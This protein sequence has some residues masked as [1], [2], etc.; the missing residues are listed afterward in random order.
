MTDTLSHAVGRRG[1]AAELRSARR[2]IFPG[3]TVFSAA[4]TP[5]RRDDLRRL[6]HAGPLGERLVTGTPANL[7]GGVNRLAPPTA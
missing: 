3:A 7:G 5:R 1:L 2:K 4:R 6:R